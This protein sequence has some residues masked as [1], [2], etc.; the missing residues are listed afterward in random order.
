MPSPPTP[1]SASWPCSRPGTAPTPGSRTASAAA[2]TPAW[3]GSRPASSR[4]TRSGCTRADRHRPDRLDPDHPARPDT[5]AKAEP[6]R[7]ATG[8]C[9]PLAGSPTAD[10]GPS[11]RS[12]PLALGRR[13]RRGVHPTRQHP[14]T[15]AG[16]TATAPAHPQPRTLG[17]PDTTP[18]APACHQAKINNPLAER[19]PPRSF[20]A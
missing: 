10:G 4:S 18:A 1:R 12:R 13:T 8:C 20:P 17:D 6:K 11:S 5:L 9:T 16:L 19:C 14:T 3:A 7:C 2:R 15:A